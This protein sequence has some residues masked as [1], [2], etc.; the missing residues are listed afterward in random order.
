MLHP[1]AADRRTAAVQAAISIRH[2]ER[3][4]H[5]YQGSR[6]GLLPFSLT[7]SNGAKAGSQVAEVNVSSGHT[8][9]RR[10][11]EFVAGKRSLNFNS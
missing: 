2:D 10:L 4:L 11:S 7:D 5:I 3:L 1:L 8:R 9:D 6:Q